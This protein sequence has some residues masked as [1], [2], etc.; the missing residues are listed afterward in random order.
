MSSYAVR[1]W[2]GPITSLVCVVLAWKEE[3]TSQGLW[4]HQR[5]HGRTECPVFPREAIAG[6]RGTPLHFHTPARRATTT[7]GP[8]PQGTSW[9][10]VAKRH[11]RQGTRHSE[12][13]AR[14]MPG[15]L[16]R[17]QAPEAGHSLGDKGHSRQREQLKPSL[18]GKK[19][20]GHPDPA[21]HGGA[22]GPSMGLLSG[23][24]T[25]GA[26]TRELR[27]TSLGQASRT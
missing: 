23:H 6:I 20:Q 22:R 7:Q 12:I 24:R 3:L 10:S 17:G 21:W 8:H 2:T 9:S 26:L 19:V 4:E 15:G 1:S 5:R 18:S 25:R 14:T 16:H 11:R 27:A 13:P